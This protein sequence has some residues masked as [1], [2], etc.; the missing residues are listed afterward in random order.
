MNET[1]IKNGGLLVLLILVLGSLLFNFIA[2]SIIADQW[3]LIDILTPFLLGPIIVFLRFTQIGLILLSIIY[4]I[5]RVRKG[6]IQAFIPLAINIGALL[7]VLFVPFTKIWLDRQF[8]SNWEDY[9]AIIEQVEKGEIAP[10]GDDELVMLPLEYQHLSKGG[11]E[12]MVDQSGG[13]KRV[14][15]FT[16]R[17]VLDNFSGFMYRSD[18]SSPQPDDF[19]GDWKQIEQIHDHW[20]FCSSY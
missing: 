8:K 20:F 14:F 17:G 6:I 10:D 15:F 7:I 4:F 5:Y 19:Y 11:G 9:Q 1:Y 18:N 13:V 16:F 12:I 3:E 2:I